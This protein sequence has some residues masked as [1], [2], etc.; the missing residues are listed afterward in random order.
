MKAPDSTDQFREVSDDF[1]QFRENH[2]QFVEAIYHLVEPTPF[3]PDTSFVVKEVNMGRY[4]APDYPLDL[5]FYKQISR[6]LPADVIQQLSS[7]YQ[8]EIPG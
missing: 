2:P 5:R 6:V 8:D 4:L 7:P 3:D 1:A